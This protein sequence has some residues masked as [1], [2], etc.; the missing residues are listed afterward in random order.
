M[1][2]QPSIALIVLPPSEIAL[3][4]KTN[5]SI[6][7]IWNFDES[8]I[9]NPSDT[10]G[11]ALDGF[12]VIY[13]LIGTPAWYESKALAG[14]RKYTVDGLLPY[15]EYNITILTRALPNTLSQ[16]KKS[17]YITTRTEEGGENLC[18]YFIML[19][20]QRSL[21]NSRNILCIRCFYQQK[22]FFTDYL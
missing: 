14:D 7:L 19:I 3:A 13:N 11:S 22:H 18:V 20:I 6:S 15:S 1:I 4:E 9:G 5:V 8:A 16:N 12:D 2:N 10:G 17:S 21:L